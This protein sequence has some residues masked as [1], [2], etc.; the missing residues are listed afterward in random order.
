MFPSFILL[1]TRQI[2]VVAMFVTL[3]GVIG[4]AEESVGKSARIY[5]VKE[6]DRRPVPVEQV[7]PIYLFERRRTGEVIPV[8][9]NR[10]R[11]PTR[12]G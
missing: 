9:L 4:R 8:F 2:L 6:L 12:G 5:E 11:V 3:S 10:A 7:R 1:F